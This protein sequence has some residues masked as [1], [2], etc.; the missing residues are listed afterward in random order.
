MGLRFW[1]ALETMA[2]MAGYEDWSKER[3]IARILELE[4]TAGMAGDSG[5]DLR[6]DVLERDERLGAILKTAV[7]GIITIDERGRIEG[8][9][10][11]AERLFGYKS[12]EVA[13]RNV[14]LLMPEPY[15]SEHDGY[16]ANY[17]RTGQPKIIGIGREVVGL[18]KDG[19]VFPMDLAVS[20]LR[21][22]ERRMYCGFVRDITE[23]KEHETRLSELAASLADKNRELESI[24]YVASHDLRSPLVNIQGFSRELAM[25]CRRVMDVMDR[26]GLM[27]SGEAADE[28]RR[29]LYEDIPEALNFIQAGVGKMEALLSGFLRFS[30]LG[31]ASLKIERLDMNRLM[32]DVLRTLEFQ[33][34]DAGGEAEIGP[35]PSCVGDSTQVNQ[36]FTNLVENAIKYRSPSRAL[37]LRIVGVES[38]K[39]C[40]YQVHDNGVGMAKEHLGRIFEIFHRLNPR[41]S[42][43]EGLGLT[44]A[45]KLLERQGGRI[46]VESQ[47]GVGSCF[48]V[49]LPSAGANGLGVNEQ[50]DSTPA[51]T[52]PRM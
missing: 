30:R 29:A 44:I 12:A 43:G 27:G 41:E 18:R 42:T 14:S 49:V 48:E 36:V 20:E 52:C 7:E 2:S 24:V 11:A 3:L 37:R 46:T 19:S 21:L 5:H 51:R 33:I 45:Q 50:P 23:R 4:G 16:M 9:N 8:F 39:E 17:A 25:A 32:E 34:K 22:G 1:V 38:G 6:R 13:G 15:H 10:P 47:P 31:R 40:L 35:L 28:L 26:K